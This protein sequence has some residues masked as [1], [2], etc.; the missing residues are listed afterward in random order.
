M[1]FNHSAVPAAILA[2]LCLTMPFITHADT[3]S[4]AAMPNLT[5]DTLHGQAN[6]VFDIRNDGGV[7]TGFCWI[8]LSLSNGR[9]WQLPLFSL[10]PGEVFHVLVPSVVTGLNL[11]VTLD[12]DCHKQVAESNET[13]NSAT[14][15]YLDMAHYPQ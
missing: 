2:A 3:S 7:S 12:V 13:D 4:T 11:V 10:T 8:T 1:R 9:V 15:R 5:I 6:R 14:T